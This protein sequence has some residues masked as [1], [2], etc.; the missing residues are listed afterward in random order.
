MLKAGEMNLEFYGLT[1]MINIF[2]LAVL[3]KA[4]GI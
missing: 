4:Y 2:G 1:L 3:I